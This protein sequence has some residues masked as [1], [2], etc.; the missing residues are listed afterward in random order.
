LVFNVAADVPPLRTDPLKLKM[1]LKNLV[2]NAIKFTERGSITV[3]ARR[4]NGRVDIGVTDTGMGIARDAIPVIFDA[5]RQ[6][7]QSSA[8]R[9]GGAGLGLYI[10]RRLLDLLGGT[11]TVDSELGRGSTFRVSLP[12]DPS[13]GLSPPS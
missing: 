8:Q 13:R 7:D 4:V 2:G 3:T 12:L 9:Q 10:T 1:V 11:I 6:V 5:F